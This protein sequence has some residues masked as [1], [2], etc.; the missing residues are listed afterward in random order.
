MLGGFVRLRTRDGSAQGAKPD[1]P[2]GLDIVGEG[3]D[4]DEVLPV[5]SPIPSPLCPRGA[6]RMSSG[7]KGPL[8][9]MTVVSQ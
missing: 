8:G 6:T 4:K 9:A 2:G 7:P 5:R 1:N 3:P